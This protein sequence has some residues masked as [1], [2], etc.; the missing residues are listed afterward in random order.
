[1]REHTIKLYS[2]DELSEAA[3]EYAHNK[4]GYMW[5][6]DF[7][8]N[9]KT[10][11][12]AFCDMFDIKLVDYNF[13]YPKNY[14]HYHV[15]DT[16]TG[17]IEIEND[18]IRI[19]KYIHN[20]FYD[21]FTTQKIYRTQRPQRVIIDGITYERTKPIPM[22]YGNTKFLSQPDDDMLTGDF[23]DGSILRPVYDCLTYKRF[24]RSYRELIDACFDEFFAAWYTDIEYSYSMEYFSEMVMLNDYEFLETGEMWK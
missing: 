5:H 1:M 17:A 16:R 7:D 15:C 13:G 12:D 11:L 24:F 14:Y 10:T 20:N 2:F 18:P 21:Y 23:P 9:Y 8:Y 3:Q 22:T 4:Y 6:N 19:A